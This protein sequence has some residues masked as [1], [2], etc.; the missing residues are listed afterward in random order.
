MK[1]VLW[2]SFSSV[3]LVAATVVMAICAQS[4]AQSL[5]ERMRTAAGAYERKDFT[6]AVA[7]W[8][9]LAEQGNA[10]AQT[11]LGA[12]YWQGEGVPRNHA[13][14]ARLYLLAARQGYARAQYDIGFMYGFGEGT[15]PPDDIQAYKWIG[16]ALERFTV[17]NAERREQAIKDR[18][19]LVARMSK[20]QLAEAE[21]QIKAWRPRP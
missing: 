5:E 14:A 3:L 16:L 17:K 10:E 2:R 12:M 9:P 20:A 7:L 19:T 11:L 6:L 15:P 13:E 8:K 4:S 18:A 1:K 21:A